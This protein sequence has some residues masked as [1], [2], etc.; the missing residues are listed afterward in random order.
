MVG[1]RFITD[2][3]VAQLFKQLLCLIYFHTTPQTE[4]F[5]DVIH[6]SAQS[7]TQNALTNRWHSKY[8]SDHIRMA[9]SHDDCS[10]ISFFLFQL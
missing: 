5:E 6:R 8:R 1:P 2:Q 4:P 7:P 10:I 9:T 3:T